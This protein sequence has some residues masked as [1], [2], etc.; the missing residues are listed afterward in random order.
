MSALPNNPS[1]S[2][3]GGERALP[4]AL[5]WVDSL[6]VESPEW[7]E[8]A[9]A[10]ALRLRYRMGPHGFGHSLRFRFPKH[11]ARGRLDDTAMDWWLD[12]IALVESIN[13]WKAACPGRIQMPPGM[14]FA[15]GERA[16]WGEIW[17]AGLAEFFMRNGIRL[18][19][20]VVRFEETKS[21][22][23][24]T[25][26]AEAGDPP[27][28][29]GALVPVGGGKDSALSLGLL[30]DWAVPTWPLVMNPGPAQGAV[31]REAGLH[32]GAVIRV[33]RQI[34]P[35]LLE[36]N[37]AG[38]LNGHVPF[39]AIL[40]FL[41][42]FAACLLGCRDVVLSNESSAD[43]PSVGEANHQYS[44]TTG[45]ERGF[46]RLLV[47][48]PGTRPNYFSLLRPLNEFQIAG[49]LGR[50]PHIGRVAVSCNR[51]IADGR[52][53]GRCAKCLSSRLLLEAPLGSKWLDSA[54]PA[55]DP[56]DDPGL[57]EA[58]GALL[59][60]VEGKPWECVASRDDC[61]AALSALVERNHWDRGKAPL[62]VREW[63]D[64]GAPGRMS[65]AEWERHGGAWNERH[66][67]PAD[68]AARLRS[69]LPS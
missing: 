46:R 51:Q 4:E 15:A 7:T 5:P 63:L 20:P 13:Y 18:S 55:G 59:G 41:S 1:L 45:F 3:A 44:K 19:G 11:A 12:R 29:T 2:L 38:W 37:K 8:T 30:A 21:C 26:G 14:V 24:D 60:L 65:P 32:D 35:M 36:L 42:S 34:D 53:C 49:L 61:R 40:A 47:A 69:R 48:A 58:F 33:D 57:R 68:W 22:R 28:S 50:F 43:E 10:I 17:S 25:L 9:E 16:F 54:F 66:A 52:W 39:S 23:S 27:E 56:L 31:L 64:A 67:L 62:L 6:T